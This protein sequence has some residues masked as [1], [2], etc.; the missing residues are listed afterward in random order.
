MSDDEIF[1][2]CMFYIVIIIAI[3][4]IGWGIESMACS[5]R[6]PNMSTSWGPIKGCLVYTPQGWIPA[7]NYRVM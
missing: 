1:V 2:G 4:L 5:A 7:D 6:F 3:T